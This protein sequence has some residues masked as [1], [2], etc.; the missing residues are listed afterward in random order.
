MRIAVLALAGAIQATS[1]TAEGFAWPSLDSVV[2]V[3]RLFTNDFIGDGKDRWRTGAYEVSVT[4][5]SHID[6]ALPSVPFELM[7]YRLRSEIIAPEDLAVA[8]P[9][10]DRPYAGVIGLGAFTHYERGAYNISFGGELVFVGPSTGL[11]DF[12]SWAHDQLGVQSP[13][14]SA[15]QLGDKIYPT[16]QGEVSRDMRFTNGVF[17]PFVEAQA[18]VESY[19]RVGF[20]TIFGKNISKNFFVREPI[21]G[22]LV[23]NVR[24]SDDRSFGFMMGADVAYVGDS[25]LLP[26]SRG[27]EVRGV[28]PRARAGFLYEGENAGFFYGVTWLGRE[29]ESQREGQVTGSLNV[30]FN[31]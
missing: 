26:E 27:Y 25:K 4:F 21:T 15:T 31:F 12:Q 13:T 3:S 11:D 2:G 18:G 16:V 5:G 7:Q 14:A 17:R 1:V 30:K 22:H 24:H 29:F 23:T 6:E 9:F 20:D 10:P 8:N 19:A 28:R